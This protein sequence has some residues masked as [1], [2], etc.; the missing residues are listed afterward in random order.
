MKSTRISAAHETLTMS[1]MPSWP[2]I[3]ARV[4]ADVADQLARQLDASTCTPARLVGQGRLDEAASTTSLTTDSGG[5]RRAVAEP[6]MRTWHC[7]G[8]HDGGE[9]S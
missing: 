3:L 8:S 7:A 1:A 9:T 6:L 5:V 2:S 4:G